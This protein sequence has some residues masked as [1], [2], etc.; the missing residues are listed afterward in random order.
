M[1]ETITPFAKT[2]WR[3]QHIPFGIKEQD[4]FGHIYC[5]GK[6][7]TGKSTLLLTIAIA[8]IQKNKGVCIIDP[9][10]DLA[11]KVLEYIP[12]HRIKDVIYFHPPVASHTIGFNPLANISKDHYHI[13]VSSLIATF[14]KIWIDSWGPRLEHILRNTLYTLIEYPNAT[15]L[16]IQPLLTNPSFRTEV[17]KH[18]TNRHV[19]LFWEQE[20]QSYNPQMRAEAIAPV[21]NKTGILYSSDCMRTIFSQTSSNFSIHECMQNSKILI[22]N[23]SK[24]LLGE[25][26]SAFLGSIVVTAIQ[27]EALTRAKLPEYKR[28]PFYLFVDEMQSFVSLS[29][30]DILS[31]ARKYKLALFLTNQFFSQ[32]DERIRKAILGNIG[33][34][35]VFRI[36]SEDAFELEKEFYPVINM[37][38]LINQSKYHLYIK[39][40][41][42]GVSSKPF[43]AKSLQLSHPLKSFKEEVLLYSQVQYGSDQYEAKDNTS[44]S[45]KFRNPTLFD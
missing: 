34:M 38:D 4:R 7:G 24:G 11:E 5:L 36:G 26:V 22:C 16:D 23:F 14:K 39:L 19:H 31:E 28:I 6:T 13:V 1:V 35:I 29:F 15:L 17:L 8:D 37:N 32:I 25:D 18:C 9:H 41:I 10:G 44:G 21:L 40:M 2:T 3:N 20:F 45:N 12:K 27:T 43:S 42:D 30:A 33:T